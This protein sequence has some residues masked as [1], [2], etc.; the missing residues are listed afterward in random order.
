MDSSEDER[1][2]QELIDQIMSV[3][4]N[5]SENSQKNLSKSGTLE[6]V[7]DEDDLE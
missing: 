5:S 2:Q 3:P 6:R 7:Y 4:M 1:H